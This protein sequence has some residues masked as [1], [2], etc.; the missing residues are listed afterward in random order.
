[1]NCTTF[2]KLLL[3]NEIRFLKLNTPTQENGINK[4]TDK[5]LS[6]IEPST[7]NYMHFREENSVSAL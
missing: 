3:V 5:Y 4:N 1:M 6:F 7:I 2:A